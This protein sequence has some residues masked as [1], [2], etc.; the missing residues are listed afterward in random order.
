MCVFTSWTRGGEAYI[1]SLLSL[2]EKWGDREL[3]SKTHQYIIYHYHNHCDNRNNN[4]DNGKDNN[5]N[6]N[7]YYYY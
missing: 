7:D 6:D 2:I 3:I 4:N 1:G 5:D